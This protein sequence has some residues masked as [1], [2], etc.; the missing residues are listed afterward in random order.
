MPTS[1]K[2]ICTRR[3]ATGPELQRC[4][5]D[6]ILIKA[7]TKASDGN[8]EYPAWSVIRC[9][10][11]GTL[12]APR[13]LIDLYT[14]YGPANW[15][16][17]SASRKTYLSN[18][19]STW[20]YHFWAT[21]YTRKNYLPIQQELANIMSVHRIQLLATGLFWRRVAKKDTSSR[22]MQARTMQMCV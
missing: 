15:I 7:R 16:A 11:A 3:D 8:H 4:Y 13:I 14:Y 18:F 19:F 21:G 9:I 10:Y 1:G 5:L 12:N 22:V 2:G 6:E 17:H 20:P